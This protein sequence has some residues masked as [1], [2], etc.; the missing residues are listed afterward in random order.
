MAKF[1]KSQEYDIISRMASRRRKLQRSQ[2]TLTSS[3]LHGSLNSDSD[4]IGTL[5]TTNIL[6]KADRSS[7]TASLRRIFDSFR[8]KNSENN[9]IVEKLHQYSW[10][11]ATWSSSKRS[12]SMPNVEQQNKFAQHN[13]SL[14]EERDKNATNN[15]SWSETSGVKIIR[16]LSDLN[17][18]LGKHQIL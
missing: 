1:E 11:Y 8:G 14:N 10:K 17:Q 7:S 9:N 16:S 6:S 4:P 18:A 15:F 13:Q 3:S 5:E 2:S 12:K